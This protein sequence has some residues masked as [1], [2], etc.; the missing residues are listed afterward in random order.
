MERSLVRVEHEIRVHFHG[1]VQ[2]R[3]IQRAD[4]DQDLA[5]GVFRLLLFGPALEEDL[6]VLWIAREDAVGV[7]SFLHEVVDVS[8]HDSYRLSFD[9]AAFR[10]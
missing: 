3:F 8:I 2:D 4:R 10:A 1:V 9:L 6:H 5:P 7:T